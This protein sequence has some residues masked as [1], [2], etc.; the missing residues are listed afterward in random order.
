MAEK[1]PQVQK[2]EA[3]ATPYRRKPY[4]ESYRHL[5]GLRQDVINKSR[6]LEQ[7]LDTIV[8]YVRDLLR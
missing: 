5:Y 7:S 6:Q 8:L 2:A 1:E 3:E 4:S